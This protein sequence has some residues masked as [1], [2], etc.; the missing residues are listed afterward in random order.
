MTTLRVCWLCKFS[1]LGSTWKPGHRL[2][3]IRHLNLDVTGICETQNAG[4]YALAIIFEDY[5]IF[6]SYSLSEVGSNISVAPKILWSQ[7]QETLFDPDVD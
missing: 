4:K 6:S 3:D 2:N 7:I 1:G 5:E